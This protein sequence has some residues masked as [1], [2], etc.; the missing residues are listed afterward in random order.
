VGQ[1]GPRHRTRCWLSLS[2]P[3][4]LSI[5]GDLAERLAPVGS[6][7]RLA[8]SLAGRYN[9]ESAARALGGLTSP[10]DA[11]RSWPLRRSRS[12]VCA[13]P[14]T[15]SIA[16]WGRWES[17]AVTMMSG[18]PVPRDRSPICR[19]RS[20]PLDQL[21]IASRPQLRQ[22]I[23]MIKKIRELRLRPGRACGTARPGCHLDRHGCSN[24]RLFGL[25]WR[26]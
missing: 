13:C 7:Y 21:M 24:P 3:Q 23:L 6:Q 10:A 11:A 9:D 8:W 1:Q 20:G 14:R 2:G 26:I 18:A 25:T 15:R 16:W 12:V 19:R 17:R 22:P 5:N 4:S